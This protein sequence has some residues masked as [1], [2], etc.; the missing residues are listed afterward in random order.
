MTLCK[1]CEIDDWTDPGF[2]RLAA[3]IMGGE[4]VQ[5]R[6]LWEF[7]QT[8]RA[9]ER[10]GLL[11]E[12][13]HILSVAAGTERVLYYLAN[14]VRR[15]VATDIYG[16]GAFSYREAASSFLE[17][18]ENFAPYPYR[19]ENLQALPMDALALS[20]PD[21]SFDAVFS[22][23]SIEHFGGLSAAK[24]CLREMERVLKPGGIVILVTD[25]SFN[26]K[27]LDQ[28]F[29]PLDMERL[30]SSSDL[31][32]IHPPSWEVSERSKQHCIPIREGNLDALPHINLKLFS[33]LFTSYAMILQKE[34]KF[35][36]SDPNQFD[37]IL[38]T[39]KRLPYNRS[40]YQ[41]PR[42]DKL[43][44]VSRICIRKLEGFVER[45]FFAR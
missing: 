25:C 1:F 26:N 32:P 4:A 12:R 34:G 17:A 20:F 2:S 8:V 42:L 27:G 43:R 14:R 15:M 7:T 35:K 6:K 38:E 13:A 31:K 22:L 41:V 36:F 40:G 28:V 3:E 16:Q 45:K 29:T 33:S 11:D 10:F 18:P 5:H 23:S 30:I 39:A 37:E 24:R 9:L 19:R 21:N 44:A